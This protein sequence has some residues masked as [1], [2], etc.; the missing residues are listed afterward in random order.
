M[1]KQ[2]NPNWNVNV[3]KLQ[4]KIKWYFNKSPSSNRVFFP[5]IDETFQ[6]RQFQTLKSY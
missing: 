4:K 5:V 1:S 3:V 6:F 2:Q